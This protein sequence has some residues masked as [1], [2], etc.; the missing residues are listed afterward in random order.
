MLRPAKHHP[1]GS[2]IGGCG[3]AKLPAQAPPYRSPLGGRGCCLP[4][5]GPGTKLTL[6]SSSRYCR[7]KCFSPSCQ[8]AAGD[9]GNCSCSGMLGRNILT[10]H[11]PEVTD[12]K[13]TQ[14]IPWKCPCPGRHVP[15]LFLV[16]P[17][18]VHL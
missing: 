10:P 16:T 18:F 14:K 3:C 7:F 9:A 11:T 4:G 17:G 6:N 2:R 13:N 1:G 5:Q 12:S 8:E 15:H